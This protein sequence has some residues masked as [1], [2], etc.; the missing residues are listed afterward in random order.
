M[1]ATISSGVLKIEGIA[2]DHPSF[3]TSP[4]K[5]TFT[6]QGETYEIYVQFH[7]V[8]SRRINRDSDRVEFWATGMGFA[9][10]EVEGGES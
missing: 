6:F 5:C 3:D 4:Q 2:P 10:I 9:K 7:D 8:K 1:K